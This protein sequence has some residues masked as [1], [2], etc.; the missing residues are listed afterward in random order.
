MARVLTT[1]LT[2][3]ASVRGK[4]DSTQAPL[5]AP[6]FLRLQDLILAGVRAG[7]REMPFQAMQI[8]EKSLTNVTVQT[9]PFEFAIP[10]A[11]LIGTVAVNYLSRDDSVIGGRVTSGLLRL[12]AICA[13]SGDEQHIRQIEKILGVALNVYEVAKKKGISSVLAPPLSGMFTN[14]SIWGEV[15]Q[16]LYGR[17]S[18]RDKQVFSDSARRL[19]AFAE[20]VAPLM[21]GLFKAGAGTDSVLMV[22]I[23]YAAQPLLRALVALTLDKKGESQSSDTL[24]DAFKE[25]SDALTRF[26]SAP[27]PAT[28]NSVESIADLL[29]I[30]SFALMATKTFD[31]RAFD[32]VNLIADGLKR[33][34]M[35]CIRA[36]QPRSSAE[37]LV[38]VWTIGRVAEQKGLQE[39]VEWLESSRA[40]WLA[41]LPPEQQNLV[42]GCFDEARQDIE[43]KLKGH[44]PIGLSDELVVALA[45]ILRVRLRQPFEQ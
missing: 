15:S 10:A 18:D 29:A 19:A 6:L 5:V 8:L 30:E 44:V 3:A 14:C 45:S 4:E 27:N 21:R 7:D 28:W 20:Q 16:V 40:Q 23:K 43:S 38:R 11:Q 13:L 37:A 33:I 34:A 1:A 39:C 35:D 41:A 32:A 26:T 31:A 17:A 12:A 24:L 36:E 9:P 42:A 25:L 22:G 2:D